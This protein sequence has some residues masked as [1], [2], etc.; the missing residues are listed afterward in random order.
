MLL[1][2]DRWSSLWLCLTLCCLGRPTGRR[3][4]QRRRVR[5]AASGSQLGS[6]QPCFAH[7]DNDGRAAVLGRLRDGGPLDF[8][9][10]VELTEEL[11]V[12]V[13]AAAPIK[14]GRRILRDADL[15]GVRVQGEARF[16]QASFQGEAWFDWVCFRRGAVF[17]GASFQ[18]DAGFGGASFAGDADFRPASFHGD[19][20][21]DQVS[22][23]IRRWPRAAAPLVP[24]AGPGQS[25]G[26]SVSRAGDA[27]QGQDSGGVAGVATQGCGDVA[28]TTGAQDAD[29]EVTQAGHGPGAV[30]VRV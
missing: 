12:E 6:D 13:L 19:A 5:L 9:A 27:Q 7:T 16:D 4:R 28:V 23:T 26:V 11:L 14:D 21:F 2:G 24:T 3:A 18:R 17:G 10:G 30:P 15:R 22:G 20:R 25:A 8:V 29:D 1:L